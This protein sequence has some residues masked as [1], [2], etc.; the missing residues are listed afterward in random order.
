MKILLFGGSGQLGVE[1][2][3]RAR[4]LNFE[5]ISP[6]QSE[7]DISEEK[8][9]RYLA[10]QV[11]PYI[12][13]NC[14]AYTLVDKAEEEN[15]AAFSIN[16]EGAKNS[17]LA[18][19][20]CKCRLIHISTD[21]VF[22]GDTRAPLKEGDRCDPINVYGQSKLAGENE[23][24]SVYP[25]RSLILRTS[26]L[27]GNKG[28]NFVRTMLDLFRTKELVKVVDDQYMSPT[29][30][31]WLAEVILD[32]SRLEA[33]GLMHACCE[34]ET[35]W[36]GF[37]SLILELSRSRVEASKNLRIEPIPSAQFPRPAARPAYSVLNCDLLT[38]TLGRRPI[39]WQD[40][41][42]FY[43]KELQMTD[44]G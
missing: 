14:A 27:Y 29:W 39:S 10:K 6:V 33:S 36:Y 17:A 34:G 5:I 12:I 26:S 2:S 31:G 40:G 28:V 15:D 37:A 8:Q 11:Q 43:L 1:I 16:C 20:D 3:K 38:N 41:L 24:R 4:D 22:R 32:L 42:R 35:N 25:D 13:V 19:A 18:A 30:A 7:L 44:E 9:V 21:Y 23:I